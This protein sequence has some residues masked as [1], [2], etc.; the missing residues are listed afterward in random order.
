MDTTNADMEKQKG[1]IIQQLR[2]TPLEIKILILIVICLTLGF[3]T[4][5]IYSLNSESKA[6]MHQHRL[7]SH[8]FGETLISGI[9]NIM[10]SGRAPYV[11]AFVEEAREEFDKVGEFHLFNNKAEEIFPAKDPHIS[12]PIKNPKLKERLEH[13]R[14]SDNL[15]P[16]KNEASCKACHADEIENRGAVQLDFTH[17]ADWEKALIQVV[18]G[19]FQAIM[20]SGKGEYA[21]TLLLDINQLMGVNLVQVYDEDGIYVAFGDDNV[22]VDEDTLEDVAETFHDKLELGSTVKKNN[23]H[24]APFLNMESC[25]VCH[26][27]DSKLRGILAMKM[28]TDNVQREH[29]INSVIIGFKNL[30]RLQRASY[31]GAYIDEIRNLSFVQNFQVFDNGHVSDSGFHELWVPNPDYSS[32]TSDTSAANLIAQNNLR[33]PEEDQLEYIEQIADIDHLTQMVPIINDEKCQ[34]CHEPPEKD[35]PLYESQKDKWKVRSVV[36]VSTSMKDIQEEIQK[37]TQASVIV[38]LV[39]I[40]LVTL[41]LRLFMR[42]TVLKP[43]DVIGGVADKIGEGDLSVHAQVKSQDEIG[44]LAQRINKMIKGLQERLHLTKFVSD[45]ALTAVKKVGLEGLKM[46]GERKVATIMETD[47]RGFTS[48]SEKME[49]EEVVSLLNTYLDKQTE[50]IQSYGG[51]ID[52]FIG[53]A[54]LAVFT[55]EEMADNAVQ[56]AIKI[57]KEINTLNQ[58]LGK[59]T[60]IGIGIDTGPLVMGAMGSKDRMDFTVIGDHVN[61]SS[62]LCDA[63][64]PGEV[65]ISENTEKLLKEENY[66]LK[67]LDPIQVKGK[68]KPIKIYKIIND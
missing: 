63:A 55:G 60:M 28:Q 54:V 68:E 50:M 38:G 3:G 61:T 23:Y 26:G 67:Q 2:R 4:Y 10:L 34:A 25:H 39:T 31:A 33:S 62:R 65:I 56:C 21:D 53:D 15:Y 57:Q 36:K 40:I 19:A 30:M 14:F 51:D 27:P 37:N 42:A 48:M 49:P 45:E 7:R 1:S 18:Q 11:R 47:I 41:L 12:I 13:N 32:I 64:L 52:K 9:R 66:Q 46:G 29:V 59:N 58:S 20:L 43:L 16:I 24:F 8:L 44:V 6:L 22:E 5:V 35:T 17:N